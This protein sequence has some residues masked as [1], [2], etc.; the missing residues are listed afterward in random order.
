[1]KRFFNG[2]A[3]LMLSAW[4][5]GMWAVGY[6]AAPVL[7]LSLPDKALAGML[8]GKLFAVTAYMGMVSAVYLGIYDYTL[9]GKQVL[10]QGTFWIIV[11]LLL[12]TLLGQFAIQPL[13]AEL[14]ALALP[15]YVMD[16]VY[17]DRFSLLHG[18][19]SIIYLLQSLLGAVLLLKN[20]FGNWHAS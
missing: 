8:A 19:A 16:S 5:G 17:A 3:I 1:M 4:V 11:V 20:E 10:R 6:I 13:L 18:A 12:L 15:L 9:C 14:K 7:F 2:L